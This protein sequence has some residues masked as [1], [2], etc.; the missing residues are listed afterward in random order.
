MRDVDKLVVTAVAPYWQKVALKLG[1]EVP[2]SKIVFQNHPND[3]EGACRDMLDRWLK[4]KW[5]T[6]REERTWSTLLTALVRAGF[7][8]LVRSLQEKAFQCREFF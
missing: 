6:G 8:D 2:V 5:Q 4:D 1:V 3:C 7:V